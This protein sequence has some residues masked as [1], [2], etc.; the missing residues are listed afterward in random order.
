MRRCDSADWS[1]WITCAL[2]DSSITFS[3]RCIVALYNY[4]KLLFSLS[5]SFY[6]TPLRFTQNA[7]SLNPRNIKRITANV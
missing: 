6:V 7:L 1:Y 4:N 5:I 2:R 3:A